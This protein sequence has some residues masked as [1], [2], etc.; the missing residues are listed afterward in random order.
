[1]AGGPTY[2]VQ[3]T[4]RHAKRIL[5][6]IV[7]KACIPSPVLRYLDNAIKQEDLIQNDKKLRQSAKT[8]LKN[9]WNNIQNM[10]VGNNS[11]ACDEAV[12]KASELDYSPLILTKAF[13]LES[14]FLGAL[15]AKIA[16][17]I[18]LS[19]KYKSSLEFDVKLA[20]LELDLVNSGLKKHLLNKII[21]HVDMAH[22]MGKDICIIAGGEMIV[23]VKGFG[24][25]GKNMECVLGAV[26]ELKKQIFVDDNLLN[27]NLEFAFLSATTDGHDG[28]TSLAGA[29]IDENFM[30]L[31]IEKNYDI[32]AYLDDND[33]LTLF[34]YANDGKNLIDTKLT[35]TNVM[36]MVVLLIKV[37]K[38]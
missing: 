36:D 17:F 5:E 12:N 7:G 33:S 18:A 16:K 10:I 37:P 13:Q 35:G 24:V 14:R 1:M 31:V 34:N 3:P 29:V 23:N 26:S 20:S 32:D 21:R 11:I 9:L 4:P 28:V 27:L 2:P 22:H 6:R 25:G 38:Y 8:E 19:F 15:W 30:Q